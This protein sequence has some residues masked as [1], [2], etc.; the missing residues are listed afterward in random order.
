MQLARRGLQH[1]QHQRHQDNGYA[2]LQQRRQQRQPE[3]DIEARRMGREEGGDD[4]FAMA[5]PQRMQHAIGQAEQ[6]QQAASL[7]GRGFNLLQQLGHL[8]MQPF[9]P[10]GAL[11]QNLW[12]VL[13]QRQRARRQRKGQQPQRPDATRAALRKHQ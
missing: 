3:R 8:L 12:P 5:G 9:L 13:P 2:A 6:H 1:Y 11:Q 10:D 7:P 4:H